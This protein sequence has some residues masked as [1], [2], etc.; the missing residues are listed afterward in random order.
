MGVEEMTNA[1]ETV[2]PAAAPAVFVL[3][4]LG[5]EP[6]RTELFGLERLEGLARQLA[7]T[8]E[9]HVVPGIPLLRQFTRNQQ[10][11]VRAH[12]LINA[13]YREGEPL[14]ADAEWLLDNFYIVSEA[15][16]EIRTDLPHGYYR[17]LPKL[18]SGPLAGYPRIYALAL[19]LLSHC[20]SSLD[21]NNI[22]RFVTAYQAITPFTIGELWAIPTMLRL[23][24]IDNL[25][26]LA[27]QILQARAERGAANAW[28][29]RHLT[30]ATPAGPAAAPLLAHGCPP[31]SLADTFVVQIL[32][33]L[34][35]RGIDPAAADTWLET[36]LAGHGVTSA[37]VLRRAQQHQ[38]ANQVSIGN[39]VTSLRLLSAIDWT[40]FFEGASLVEA[41][42][43]QD[44][45][46]V[47]GR[48]DFA[49]RDR[50]RRRVEQLARGSGR[51]EI[52][53]VEQALD[54][55]G[56]RPTLE[57]SDNGMP[58]LLPSA[59]HHVGHFLVGSGRRQLEADLGFRP[60]F[61]ERW[62]QLVER[63]AH[64]IYFGG[65]TLLTALLVAAVLAFSWTAG[66][67]TGLGI[68]LAVLAG[69][70]ASELAT[71]LTH[72][73][74][75]RLVPP[76]VLP[77]LDFHEGIP[78]DHATFVVMPSM[79][80]RPESARHL[81][82]RVEIH[83]L[84]NPD[85]HLRF[86][87]L[88][89]FADAPT[90]QMPEDEGY[91]QDVLAGIKL[92]NDR[93][94]EEGPDRFFLCHRRRLWN[95]SEGCWMGWERKRGK[96]LEFNRLLRG[97][98]A[99]SF[100]VVS[101]AVSQLPRIRYVITLDADTR[102]P[103]ETA[104]RLVAT[105]AHPLNH[106]RF[107]PVQKRVVEGYAV[108][109]PRISLTLAG[110]EKSLFARVF[111]G[112]AGID[113]YTSAVSD[114]YQDLFGVGSFTGKGV[115][116]VDAFEASVGHT[117]PENR[118]LSHDLI[119]G[120]F[121]RCGLAT[122][123]EML[124]EF[125][126]RY[127]AHARREHR[128]VRGDWQI[129]S[130]LFRRVPGPR[131]EARPNTLPF[132]ERWK[133]F[134]NLRRSLLAPALLVLALLAWFLAPASAWIGTALV[135]VVVAWPLMLQS[136]GLVLR[137]VRQ[138][139]GSNR[140][141]FVDSLA[142]TAAQ[143]LFGVI[144]L[145]EQ[146]RYMVDAIGRTLWRLF[147][148][149]RNLLEWE[150]AASTERRLG[151]GLLDSFRGMWFGPLL[152]VVTTAGLWSYHREAPEALPAASALLL[153]W[154]LSPA[155]AFWISRPRPPA[156]PRLTPVEI[157]QLRLLA[158][159][160]WCFFEDYVQAEDHWLPPDNYQED[161][162]DEI[163]HRTSP[164]NIGLYLLSCVAAHDL[165]F[166]TL[167]Q[168]LSRLEKAF[169][170][171]DRLEHFHGHLHNWYD[172]A[173]LE[174]LQ[175]IY[176]STV[177]S[178][179]FLA[180]LLTL[181]QALVEK[182]AD[183]HPLW[184]AGRDGLTDTLGLIQE[185]LRDLVPAEEGR[186]VVFPDLRKDLSEACRW[187]A[188]TP[189]G[190]AEWNQVLE[191]LERLSPRLGEHFEALTRAIGTSPPE[192]R[193]WLR[194]LDNQ[195]KAHR[196]ESVADDARAA[197]RERCQ[198][199]ADRA[200]Q[201]AGAMDFHF[202]YNER[203]HLFSVGFNLSQGRLDNAHYDLLASE[204]SL[205]SYLM[206]ARGDV[207]R[208][209]W[210]RLGRP[211]TRAA[212]EL[213]LLSWGG[214][215]FEYLMPRL[216]LRTLPGTLLDESQRAAVARQ[217]EYGRQC[218]VPWGISE[219]AFAAVDAAL[220]YQYQAFGVPG[221]GLKR[222]LGKDLV[223]APYA[224]LLAVMIDHK[225]AL[226]NCRHL[227]EEGAEGAYGFY[228]ALDF[229]AERQEKGSGARVV[230]CFMAHHQGMSL[231]A[232]TNCLR[233]DLMARRF[234][235][236]PMVH[237]SELLLQ[238][239]VPHQAPL[240]QAQS[241]ELPVSVEI[242]DGQHLISRK[243]TTPHTALPRTHL[244]SNGQYTVMVTN[245][246]AGHSTCNGL[247]VS[248][249]REDR[250]LDC[251]GQFCYIRDLRGGPV[252]STGYQPT[253][254]EADEYE[255]VLATDKAEFR[256][257]DSG[258]ETRC[259]VTV[260]PENRAEVRR[261]TLTNHHSQPRRLELTSY[262]EVVLAAHAADQ[263]HP[264]FGK[265]FL[266]TEFIAS[267]E[268]LL[269]RRRPRAA[270]EKPVWAVHVVAVDGPATGSVQY[271]TDRARFLG[272]GRTPANPAALD[273]GRG[274]VARL[275]GTTGPVLDP[276]LSL[277]R[278]VRIAADAS[279]RIAFTTA[280]AD[281]RE[282]ALALADQYH[283][284][285]HVNRAFELAWA[286]TQVELRHLQLSATDAQLFQR[287]AG[288]VLYAGPTL[289]APT[290]L[291]TSNRLGQ[292]AL[293]RHGV[294]GDKP[295]VL[296]SISDAEHIP[297]VR[298]LLAAHNYWRL[299]GLEV[300]LV[301]L[302]E[303]G[304]GYFEDLHQQLHSLVRGSDDRAFVD[305]PGGVFV[306]RS[307]HL[308]AE[309]QILLKTSAR[310]WFDGGRGP[311][312][313]Q[314]N[315]QTQAIALPTRLPV[316]KA[317]PERA[318][319]KD[320]NFRDDLLF[321]NGIGGFTPDG[322]EYVI[323]VK[324]PDEGV[325]A[326]GT[327]SAPQLPPAPWIN[328]IA[329]PEFG[330]LISESGSGYTWVGNSQTQRLTP[331]N[332]DPVAD[333]PGE[334]VYLR[335][336]ETGAVWT[337]TPLPIAAPAGFVAR[338]GQGYTVFE[339]RSHGL[340]QELTMFV[341]REG[342]VKILRLRVRNESRRM[343]RLS[344]GFFAEWVL[345]TER[346][347]SAPHVVTALDEASGAV[348]ARNPFSESMGNW[349]A[350]A[351]V[352]VRPRTLTADRAEFLGR[353]GSLNAPAALERTGLSGA[354]G[355]ALDP[356]AALL[357]PFELNAGAEKDIIFLLGAAGGAE[358]M[359]ALLRRY[360]EPRHVA[361]ALEDVKNAWDRTLTAVQVRTPNPA[362]DL[363]VN[364]WLLYQV[365]ACRVWARSALYQSGGAYGFRDQLQDVLALLHARPEE[366]RAQ[367]LRAAGRQ[368]SEGDVQH[369][370]HPP[371]G[372]GVRTRCSDDFLWLPFAALRY[373]A[374]TGDYDVL[375]ESVA[376]LKAPRLEP[377]QE[378]DYRVPEVSDEVASVYEHCVRAIENAFPFG[379]RGLPHI[380]TGDWNDG[381]NRVGHRGQ[382]ES[383]WLGW[384]LATILPE[385]ANL[386]E[387]R[388]DAVRAQRYR[389]VAKQLRASIEQH[390]WDGRWYCRAFFDDDAVLGS[391]GNDE[392][393]IDSL[394]QS[395]A[396]ISGAADA[397]RCRQALA[398]VEEFLVKRSDQLIL[399]LSPPF[400]K[401]PLEPG[402]IKGY[403]PGIRENGGQYT[404]AALWVV[405][406]VALSGAG[407]RAMELLDLLNPVHHSSTPEAIARYRVEPYAVAADV[408]SEPSHLGR[409]GWT[410][411]TGSAGWF[412]QVALETILGLERRGDTIAFDPCIPAGWREFEIRYRHGSAT[413]HIEVKNPHGVVRGVASLT[414]DGANMD[415]KRIDLRDDGL[416]HAVRVD[417]G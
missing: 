336:D 269:C 98:T 44:P 219:S 114:V 160:T 31:P 290:A 55:C 324:P 249:W 206:I 207:P 355:P 313:N 217:I 278:R 331:W 58:P 15:L 3:D 296:V 222:G 163:A 21:E 148:R 93:Y 107:D 304:S 226:D 155:V 316:S 279:V 272:R 350:F 9:V 334:V 138:L 24:L 375:D 48:Q 281:S 162:K 123:I 92:L 234:H 169:Q 177:D 377:D 143:S 37:D 54:R 305:K 65:V 141:G 112:S 5:K 202:L 224:T 314:L 231:L 275:S 41:R 380:G 361:S 387:A 115:Y 101:G 34:R 164:T 268:A 389:T 165:G 264:A 339:H 267:E 397:E 243:L 204:A 323:Q 342:T 349:S 175:P 156:E 23:G 347:R 151:T 193:R 265:L 27:G 46:G 211:L 208:K 200:E 134:D 273:G 374:V 13:A 166:V 274:S 369:W 370:W 245:A 215:M 346:E 142:D 408:Y 271:E 385:F 139:G 366:A 190:R 404:H 403:V 158:L 250:T 38:A 2:L 90:E 391:A 325:N 179:N 326:A 124:D 116:D 357:A 69:I 11:L 183:A 394:A 61:R 300:D 132:V 256:R 80:L 110:A 277:R 171:L 76:R 25:R 188:D 108:L 246:G 322:R 332:N 411:Y 395:W 329:N 77:K 7:Q 282:E 12:R 205:T 51:D 210:F 149:R 410:W 311:L 327:P 356:C 100:S 319:V 399:L 120:N 170:T 368:F 365:L 344:A 284:F 295:I 125:P 225:A 239:R 189:A 45:A 247:D 99:T 133:I 302:N 197:L 294:S 62:L 198:S 373:L 78:K 392:C 285:H 216:L 230:K 66:A 416:S 353:N 214:T 70:P 287:L 33:V 36:C 348:T 119:E 122:D 412:Y 182:Q 320:V 358:E 153:A 95:E 196:A 303:H 43:R 232:L 82:E 81:L 35:E 257:L 47:Y 97:A 401:G 75:L 261:L 321:P 253:R 293:W 64:G 388:G 352:S 398:A 328:V 174:S 111:S 18:R 32:A 315:V 28:A 73:V 221:L 248:R 291:L 102:M 201:R 235:A 276:I 126:A 26:R 343:R 87:L 67:A 186:F 121:A 135:V 308:A 159:K 301:I 127:H 103:H 72:S 407:T 258:I 340:T 359:R 223:I 227:A 194:H 57:P 299:K 263:A 379:S 172:T 229:T 364:R 409:G 372:G 140:S 144:F 289:R 400:D 238:E 152:A 117:F 240:A 213:A 405:Q 228:D 157:R 167:E 333:A 306:R 242:P 280:V 19:E 406:A 17:L 220:N 150:T 376:F 378:N 266:E 262:V 254:R 105:M 288:H 393:R 147:V 396:V 270:E 128:W 131:G 330:F 309:D 417:M 312:A 338:H 118:I 351:D 307:S 129:L 371:A 317:A 30:A 20:D 8:A 6:L 241:D 104:Q 53:V 14:G 297:L 318:D 145:A 244:L 86:A 178:G 1:A 63:H 68:L 259:E 185:H 88:T 106:P 236:E 83:Y 181:K 298:Q 199:L 251:W 91:V 337:P 363:L 192:L 29:A 218:G 161:P 113:P 154:L 354:V 209:H 74:I 414:L 85:P 49:T 233:R 382:G 22:S 252:W 386:A 286:H 367:L 39:C 381:M 292:S 384:F 362:L 310:C 415:D 173:N 402:Y 16:R 109:Q 146:A 187:L 56:R 390:A 40:V 94:R 96:L 383:V 184:R 52:A 255:V 136:L 84:S 341:P 195:V 360:R 137:R 283:D 237:A 413:Y 60:S 345:G 59:E 180:C 89:D 203:H 71:R 212:G 79:L 335:D 42:L 130:W 168:C 260:S 4:P 176:I 50:Y 191:K 10:A